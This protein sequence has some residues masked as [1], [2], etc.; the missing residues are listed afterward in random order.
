MHFVFRDGC[1]IDKPW[2]RILNGTIYDCSYEF[3]GTYYNKITP[4]GEEWIRCTKTVPT[5]NGHVTDEEL[6]R[7]HV[8]CVLYKS[9]PPAARFQN[10]IRSPY[11]TVPYDPR[12]LSTDR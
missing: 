5:L 9:F 6:G 10:M 8:R 3:D 12:P 4:Y 11:R 7:T 1:A 2:L